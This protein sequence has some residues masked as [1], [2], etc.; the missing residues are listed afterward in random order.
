VTESAAD[1]QIPQQDHDVAAVLRV[2]PFRRLWIALS[3][4]S[5]GDWLGLLATTALAAQLAGGSY[6]GANLAVAGVLILRLAPAVLLGPLA[7]ALADRL[8]RRWTMVIGDLL[9][10]GLFVSIP[11]AGTLTWLYVATVLIECVALF[12]MPAKEATVPNIVPRNRLEAA[13]QMSLATTYGTA[14]LAA[15]AFSGIALL[16]GILDNFLQRLE[17]NPVDL[18]LYVN[19]VTFLVSALTISRLAIPP[20]ERGDVQRQE[21][22]VAAILH[23]WRYIGT[24][25]LIRGLV[26]G[27]LGAFAAAGFVIG[28]APTFVADLGAGQPGY[29]ALFGAVFIGLVAGMWVGP[30]LL[31]GFSRRRL[32]G[33]ALVLAGCFLAALAVIPNIVMA[34]A[35]TVALGTCGGV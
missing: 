26:L 1:P 21:S 28:L 19:A 15:L 34:F 12:W 30:R 5:F 14:P 8:D 20:R 35:F 4:S 23:G 22:V 9:R 11:L 17:T 25:P 3:L 6:A 16:N 29:G 18:A 31:A 32:F 7:G 24:T 13:N 10:C 27:M 33:L 2:T